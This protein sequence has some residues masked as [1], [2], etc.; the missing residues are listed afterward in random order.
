MQSLTNRLKYKT[1]FYCDGH[2]Y[3]R[4]NNNGLVYTKRNY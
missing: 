2:I 4:L 3:D 1:E